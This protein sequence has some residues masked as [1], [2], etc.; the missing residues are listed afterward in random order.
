MKKK[1]ILFGII[2]GSLVLALGLG[3]YVSCPSTCSQTSSTAAQL[4]PLKASAQA[5]P[6]SSGPSTKSQKIQWVTFK[7]A[8]QQ[9]K[10]KPKKIFVDLYTDWCGWCKVMD[11]KAFSDPQ[12]IKYLNENY[13]AVKFD[14]EQKGVVNFSGKDF[15]FIKSGRSGYHELAAALTEGNLA[16]PTVVLID[17]QLKPLTYLGGYQ[18]PEDLMDILVYI[19]EG[20]YVDKKMSFDDFKKQRAKSSN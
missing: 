8:Q 6:T 14:A 11:K 19:N 18:S 7:Q 20:I 12:V 13:Y 16:Y 10:Q 9:M 2:S 3:F 4:L 15:K 1:N 5:L 17:E